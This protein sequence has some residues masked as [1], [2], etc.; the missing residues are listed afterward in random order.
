[1]VPRA[2]PEPAWCPWVVPSWRG[3]QEGFMAAVPSPLSVS[4][5][6][7]RGR[8]CQVGNTCTSHTHL[9]VLLLALLSRK[10]PSV[11]SVAQAQR[12]VTVMPPWGL[13][14]L[15]FCC[16]AQPSP[17]SAHLLILQESPAASGTCQPEERAQR[18]WVRPWSLRGASPWHEWGQGLAG[19]REKHL[20]GL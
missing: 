18:G 9:L 12:A 15:S 17:P 6:L 1:M 11:I 20:A 14:L 3:A 13:S 2:T 4:A 19:G 5:A 8:R 10:H 16:P 7:G